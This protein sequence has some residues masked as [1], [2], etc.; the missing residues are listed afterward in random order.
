MPGSIGKLWRVQVAGSEAQRA[1]VAAGRKF[2]FIAGAEGS[3]TTVLL[4]LLSA[5]AV[6]SSLG[7]NY[8]KPPPHPAI[9]IRFAPL[10][11]LKKWDHD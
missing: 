11:P 10:E 6:A 2:N 5:P 8:V 4:R 7:G 1:A 9:K 3:G